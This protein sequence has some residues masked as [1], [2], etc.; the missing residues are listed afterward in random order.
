M[1]RLK[2]MVQA[3]GAASNAQEARLAVALARDLERQRQI[4]GPR[5]MAFFALIVL[6][7]LG[8]AISAFIGGE[9]VLGAIFAAYS[10]FGVWVFVNRWRTRRGPKLA[11][12]RN[13]AYLESIDESS[14]APRERENAFVEPPRVDLAMAAVA[15]TLFYTT[16]FG[17][18][19]AAMDGDPITVTHVLARGALFGVFMTV[20][21][22]TAGRRRRRR[23][24]ALPVKRLS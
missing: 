17:A 23:S 8:F 24:R 20:V 21:N 19:T 12:G 1:R 14:N 2:R 15:V 18:L 13:L 22:L 11:E 9:P 5:T 3:G 7:W 10:V 4:A 16:A 6:G